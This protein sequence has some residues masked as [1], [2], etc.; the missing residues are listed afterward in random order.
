VAGRTVAA[1]TWRSSQMRRWPPPNL[2]TSAARR[3]GL[4]TPPTPTHSRRPELRRRVAE[5]HERLLDTVGGLLGAWTARWE[6][7]FTLP[8]KEVVRGIDCL[9]RGMGLEALLADQ[10]DPGH[11]QR[12]EE[13]FV[14]C[15]MGLIRALG[16]PNL[17][18]Q[19]GTSASSRAP[20][21]S[22]SASQCPRT[23]G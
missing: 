9:S 23:G 3:F 6:I 14:A 10:P 19:P 8:A 17:S 4:S 13:M 18:E 5:Q 16:A 7:E 12:F 11:D 21:S 20:L 2:A 22:N 15:A 1:A